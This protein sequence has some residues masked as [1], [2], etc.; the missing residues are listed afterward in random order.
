MVDFQREKD[1]LRQIA[2]ARDAIRRKHR[3]LKQGKVSFEKALDETFKPIVSPLEK[4]VEKEIKLPDIK[5]EPK[6]ETSNNNEKDAENDMQNNDLEDTLFNKTVDT[7]FKSVDNEHE[8]KD[9]DDEYLSML[10]EDPKGYIDKIFGIRDEGDTLMIGNSPI[11]F[12]NKNVIVH[13]VSY[14]KTVGLQE[15]LF[16]RDPDLGFIKYDDMQ[17]YRKILQTTNAHRKKY[18]KDQPIR[19]QNSN[20]YNCSTFR[21]YAKDW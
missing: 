3:L 14:P 7:S 15:L 21:Y 8:N 17:S 16:K 2:R 18:S 12:T 4:L 13:N 19:R 5:H 11:E 10:K 9:T 6:E 20:K 1:T